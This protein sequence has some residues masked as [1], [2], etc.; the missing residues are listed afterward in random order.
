MLSL[1]NVSL[2]VHQAQ[3]T[4]HECEMLSSFIQAHGHLSEICKCV[5]TQYI[6]KL[7]TNGQIL[8]APTK[9][10]Q[11][12]R[13]GE[14]ITHRN[15]NLWPGVSEL[16]AMGSTSKKQPTKDSSHGGY[17][18]LASIVAVAERRKKESSAPKPLT[19]KHLNLPQQY[20]YFDLKNKSNDQSHKQMLARPVS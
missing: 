17:C 8:F 16:G 3:C 13:K 2:H 9:S 20:S 19:S 6:Q 5:E 12:H 18:W 4:Q 1:W 11:Q 15:E 10:Q 14:L 7:W